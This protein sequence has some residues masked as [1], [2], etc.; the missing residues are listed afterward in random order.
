MRMGMFLRNFGPASTPEIIAG[1][2]TAA[3]AIGLDDLWICDHI[4]IPPEEATESG[5]RYL[6]PLTTL[7]YLAAITRRI[8]IGVSVLIVPYRPAL[9]TLKAIATIQEL[10]GGRLSLGAGVGWMEAEFRA[11]GVERSKRAALTDEMLE[12]THTCFANDEVDLN[13]QRFIFKPR[14]PRPPLLIG[15]EAPHALER[16]VRYGDG[17]I[18]TGGDPEKLRKPIAELRQSMAAC[19]KLPPQVIT[20]TAL[21]L[22]DIPRAAERLAALADAGVTGVDHAGRYSNVEEFRLVAEKLTEAKARSGV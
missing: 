4:A 11:L 1:C 22:D 17:W 18:P 13:G 5:G 21:P 10:S 2:A 6:D 16:A 7:A 9:P 14:P 19:G 20:L 15:G 3:E 8:G 12:F